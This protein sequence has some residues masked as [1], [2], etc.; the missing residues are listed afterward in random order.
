MAKSGYD[1]AAIAADPRYGALQRR[2]TRLLAGLLAIALAGY[3][4]LS[5]GA[6][7]LPGLFA[8]R[9]VGPVNLGIVLALTEFG[10]VFCVAVIYTRRANRDFDRFAAELDRLAVNRYR[11][12]Q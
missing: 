8:V 3:F 7:I 9:V 2:R 11:H 5:V 12:G 6:A 1:W 4:L 10:V